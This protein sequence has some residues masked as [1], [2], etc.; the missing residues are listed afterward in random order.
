M[1]DYIEA[2]RLNPDDADAYYNR[3]LIYETEDNKA[4]AAADFQVYLELGGGERDGDQ[5]EVEKRIRRLKKA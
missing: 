1:Q 4:A 5:A 3:A 2:I